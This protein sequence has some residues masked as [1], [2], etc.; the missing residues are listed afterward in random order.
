MIV[1]KF[2]ENPYYQYFCGNKYFEHSLPID[3]S[4]MT[5]APEVECISTGKAYMRYGF[6]CKVQYCNNE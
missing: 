5:Y 1:Q 2:V 6:G 3:P 4:S